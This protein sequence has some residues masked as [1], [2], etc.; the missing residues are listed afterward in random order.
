MKI[1]ILFVLFLLAVLLG[2]FYGAVQRR[3]TWSF[4]PEY[5]S[6]PW[7]ADVGKSPG[8]QAIEQGFVAIWALGLP[9]ALLI[10]PLALL[11]RSPRG[12]L[13]GG[14]K[15]CAVMF[16]AAEA[17][18]WSRVA[19]G[20]SEP[21]GLWDQA[22]SVGSIPKNVAELGPFAVHRYL[23]AGALQGAEWSAWYVGMLTAALF[24]VFSSVTFRPR[25]RGQ[26]APALLHPHRQRHA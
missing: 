23:C 21:G 7:S 11:R 2:G 5:F 22:L 15:A 12:I 4:S 8:L 24:L 20:W 26:R 13:R 6:E 3:V 10:M 18:L 9:A 25:R 16:V 1:T 19:Y 14:L 17:Y